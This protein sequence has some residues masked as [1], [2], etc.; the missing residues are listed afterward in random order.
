M[1]VHEDTRSG[2]FGTFSQTVEAVQLKKMSSGSSDRS[3]THNLNPLHPEV[4]SPH[5]H[6]WMEQSRQL[7][8]HRVMM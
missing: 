5:M 1:S 2:K 3:E 8:G 6:T 4:V 7:P